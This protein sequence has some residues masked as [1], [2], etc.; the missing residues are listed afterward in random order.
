M[1]VEVLFAEGDSTEHAQSSHHDNTSRMPSLNRSVS[2]SSLE[3]TSAHFQR[4]FFPSDYLSP[5]PTKPVSEWFQY[6][7]T[8]FEET[9][10][11]YSRRGSVASVC[12]QGSAIR[13]VGGDHH[14][15]VD[16]PVIVSKGS[17]HHLGE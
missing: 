11:R 2:T 5:S 10:L 15:D 8:H 16:R 3:V 1:S 12:S 17:S 7:E 14:G 6:Q 13:I 4:Q 9:R